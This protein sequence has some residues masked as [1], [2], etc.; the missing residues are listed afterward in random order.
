MEICPR[1]YL[2]TSTAVA[3]F[4]A[5]ALR[6]V[7]YKCVNYYAFVIFYCPVVSCPVLVLLF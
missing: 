7:C 2:V 3:N 6:A 4:I 5:I 1:N